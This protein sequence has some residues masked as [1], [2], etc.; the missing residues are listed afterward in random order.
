MVDASHIDDR[1][2]PRF[3]P[4]VDEMLGFMAAIRIP[5]G[6]SPAGEPATPE[7]AQALHD[8]LFDRHQVE[9]PVI[10][11]LK[12]LTTVAMSYVN[13]VVPFESKK[14]GQPQLETAPGSKKLDLKITDH[15]ARAPLP[16]EATADQKDREITVQLAYVNDQ[17]QTVWLEPQRLRIG[18]PDLVTTTVTD[19]NTT[20]IIETLKNPSG[21]IRREIK[22][23]NGGKSP[24]AKGGF[25]LK[26]DD[27]EEAQPGKKDG[28]KEKK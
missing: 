7:R 20:T 2:T 23:N 17:G 28:E 12:K 26:D 3:T 4:E 14:A 1:T 22:V 5:P 11:P 25:G 8:R 24:P 10:D 6:F 15:I 21:T 27:E 19:G 16:L 9:V 18:T 13:G